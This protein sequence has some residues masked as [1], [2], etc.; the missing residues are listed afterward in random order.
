MN[1]FISA[2]KEVVGLNFTSS[3]LGETSSA[4]DGGGK[5]LSD[6]FVAGYLWLDKLGVSALYGLDVVVRQEIYGSYQIGEISSYSLINMAMRPNPDY[7]LTFLYKKIVGRQI[8]N[9][10][11][12][13]SNENLRIYAA[14]T[15][16]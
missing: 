11:F 14:S 7:W 3:W 4:Y 9:L 10:T 2:V 13:P 1:G 8:F 16:K 6:T 12:T 5:N 15:T